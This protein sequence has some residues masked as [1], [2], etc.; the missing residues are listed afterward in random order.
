MNAPAPTPAPAKAT[1][2]KRQDA[3]IARMTVSIPLNMDNPNSFSDA[4]AAVDGI[5]DKLPAGATV[6]FTSKGLG[7]I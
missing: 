4:T 6:E 1:K 3:L 7:K 5:K 2:K